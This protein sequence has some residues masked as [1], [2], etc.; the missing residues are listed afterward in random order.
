MQRLKGRIIINCLKADSRFIIR[1][2][3][4]L[5]AF[6]APFLLVFLLRFLFPLIA[7]YILSATGYS[8]DRYYVIAVLTIIPVIPMLF[9]MVYAFI[10]LDENDKHILQIIAVTPAGK[11]NF[12]IMRM[13]IPLLLSLMMVV[14]SIVLI[15]PVPSEGWLRTALVSILLSTQAPFVFMFIGS[16]AENKVE[17]LAMAKL[18]GVFLVA[19]PFGL[20]LHHPWNYLTFF[21]PLYWISWAWV[22]PDPFQSFLCVL[23]TIVMTDGSIFFFFRHFLK[24]TSV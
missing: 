2:P 11:I 6:I 20:M 19:I 5:M 24:I 9:G 17:G 21:S 22:L 14:L 10:L 13:I 16:L 12:I 18:Y 7:A 4:L 23:I 3:F 1:D 8:I 15:R